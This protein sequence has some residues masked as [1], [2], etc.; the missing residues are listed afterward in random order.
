[1]KGMLAD[2]NVWMKDVCILGSIARGLLADSNVLLEEVGILGS[3][4]RGM[5][6]D[7]N[8][9]FKRCWDARKHHRRYGG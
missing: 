6:A 9:L 4:M 5:L 3:I 2:S 1:M 8:V 7:S